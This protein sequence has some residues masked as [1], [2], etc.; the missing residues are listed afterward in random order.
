MLQERLRAEGRES[1]GVEIASS[2]PAALCTV[3]RAA[4]HCALPVCQQRRPATPLTP[5]HSLL[6]AP[7]PP[8]LWPIFPRFT[9][10][11]TVTLVPREKGGSDKDLKLLVAVTTMFTSRGCRLL[12]ARRR[13]AG[14]S[15]SLALNR[16]LLF[17][18][19]D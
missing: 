8:V 7:P 15:S 13:P 4:G 1:E 5:A 14:T 11:P 18:L 6:P 3:A 16:G 12:Q 19:K 9:P 2:H 10:P 17:T